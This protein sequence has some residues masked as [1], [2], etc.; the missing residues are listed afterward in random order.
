MGNLNVVMINVTSRDDG[1]RVF[2]RVDA[3]TETGRDQRR[4]RGDG[5]QDRQGEGEDPADRRCDRRQGRRQG[6]WAR[7]ARRDLRSTARAGGGGGRRHRGAR[8]ARHATGGS[9][10]SSSSRPVRRS[11][12]TARSSSCSP[13]RPTRQV[14]T[15]LIDEAAAGGA[16][17]EYQVLSEDAQDLLR[18]QLEDGRQGGRRSAGRLRRHDARA[19]RPGGR[20]DGFRAPRCRRPWELV[21]LG[22]EDRRRDQGDRRLGEPGGLRQVRRGEDRTDHAGGSAS[23]AEPEIQYF[24]VHNYLTAG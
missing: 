24:D 7:S 11:K 23:S 21:P 4:G 8:R 3:A 6:R 17:V 18:M 9:P 2:D 14:I 13:T 15:K 20:A 5:L 1:L 19:V 22:D 16:K 12:P 10:T